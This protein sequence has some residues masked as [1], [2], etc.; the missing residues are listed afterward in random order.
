VFKI[1]RYLILGILI[2]VAISALKGVGGAFKGQENSLVLGSNV[3]VPGFE[4]P[5]EFVKN[6]TSKAAIFVSGA[7][8]GVVNSISDQVSSSI[9]NKATTEVMKNFN[10]LGDKEKEILKN[11]ICQ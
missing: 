11:A 3:S 4:S 8:D 7:V 1:L 6:V 10:N 9:E 5:P 2:V